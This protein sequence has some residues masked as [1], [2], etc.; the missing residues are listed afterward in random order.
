MAQEDGAYEYVT[1]GEGQAMKLD[2]AIRQAER[3]PELFRRRDLVEGVVATM[4]FQLGWNSH[5][6]QLAAEKAGVSA[7]RWQELLYEVDV[8]D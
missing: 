1:A 8:A 6:C 3:E 7:E 2:E 4:R 5:E